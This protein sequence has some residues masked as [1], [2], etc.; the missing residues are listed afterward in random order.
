MLSTALSKTAGA[1]RQTS[2]S[3]ALV[4]QQIWLWY[5]PAFPLVQTRSPRPRL[6]ITHVDPSAE[7]INLPEPRV[8]HTSAEQ[9]WWGMRARHLPPIIFLHPTAV[10]RAV[11]LPPGRKQ[12]RRDTRGTRALPSPSAARPIGVAKRGSCDDTHTNSV[13]VIA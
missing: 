8:G 7:A 1:S 2:I 4:K 3:G 13:P 10:G 9:W 11:I 6:K 5:F 12:R